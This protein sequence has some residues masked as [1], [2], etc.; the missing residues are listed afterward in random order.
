[1][2]FSAFEAK[3][4][5]LMRPFEYDDALF[6]SGLLLTYSAYLPFLH[7]RGDYSS[8]QRGAT[9]QPQDRWEPMSSTAWPKTLSDDQCMNFVSRNGLIGD[10]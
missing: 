8:T 5:L 3:E 10:T 9:Y 6:F 4:S 1:M 7:C 2:M